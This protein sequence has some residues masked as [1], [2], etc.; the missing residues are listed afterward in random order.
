MASRNGCH[1]PRAIT[2]SSASELGKGFDH[3]HY[4]HRRNRI[5]DFVL[6]I[7]AG[8]LGAGGAQLGTKPVPDG[9]LQPL[10]HN[11]FYGP[12]RNVAQNS[13]RF[14]QTTNVCIKPVDLARL[15][16]DL[17]EYLPEM[18]L[19]NKQRQGAEAQIAVLE[20]ELAG[21]QDHTIIRQ[22]GRS[23]RTIEEG[24]HWESACPTIGLA[25]PIPAGL[26]STI[27]Q[28]MSGTVH[29]RIRH[30][31]DISRLEWTK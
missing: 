17:K 13:E 21:E 5:L 28:F 20:A 15:V 18:N 22:A 14:N 31:W 30:G 27:G 8:Y 1:M 7:N 19:G 29:R 26:M 3:R 9:N 25:M 23:L 16:V 10:V 24:P 2:D 4:R 11:I 6:K 12:V